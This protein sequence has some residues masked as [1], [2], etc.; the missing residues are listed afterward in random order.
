MNKLP[1][2]GTKSSRMDQLKLFKGCLPQISL[3]HLKRYGLLKH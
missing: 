3:G 1:T 2:C